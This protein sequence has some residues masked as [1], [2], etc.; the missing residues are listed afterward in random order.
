M[1]PSSAPLNSAADASPALAR[2]AKVVVACTLGL[3]FLGGLVT[4]WQAGMAVPDWPLS[5]GSLNPHGWWSM[6]DVRLEHGHRMAASVVGMLITILCAW[7]WRNGWPLLCAALT[8]VALTLLAVVAHVP[9][10]VIM[11]VSIWSF[12][13]AFAIA[14]LL[15][16]RRSR[17]GTVLLPASLRWMAFGAFVT[18]CL[19]ATLGGLRVVLQNPQPAVAMVF[20]IAH[21]CVAQLMLCL[22]VIMAARLSPVWR[23]PIAASAPRFA[24]LRRLSWAGT[25]AILLQL[26]VGAAMRHQGGGLA[27]PFFPHASAD[28]S[29]MPPMHSAAV[30]LNFTH[31]RV[32]PILISLLLLGTAIGVLS[33]GGAGK[34]LR[35]VSWGVIGLLVL[36]VFLGME[37]VW[38]LKQPPELTTLHVLNGAI[39]LA[40]S[41][42][43]SLRL[44]RQKQAA[45]PSPR[46]STSPEAATRLPLSVS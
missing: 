31:T 46:T 23:E 7:V 33:A 43:L 4:S 6:D 38:R 27:I 32:G 26:L 12:A 20:R 37:V 2:Y 3:I 42:L 11:H 44:Q 16:A 40:T 25:G 39:L 36:Q 28:G 13:V 45:E 5:F 1:V 14:L 9:R 29:W 24:G 19:Q 10:L 35:R 8:S 15:G 17:P 21:G 41:L 34:R 22:L 30:D 18:V